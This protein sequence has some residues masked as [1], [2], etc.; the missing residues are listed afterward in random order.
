M[1]ENIMSKSCHNINTIT[2]NIDVF[3]AISFAF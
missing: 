1:L 3:Q 2:L